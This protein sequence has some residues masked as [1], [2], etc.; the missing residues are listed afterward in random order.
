MRSM[1]QDSIEKGRNGSRASRRPSGFG[2]KILFQ[3]LEP[4]ILLC[5]DQTMRIS[6]RVCRLLVRDDDEYNANCI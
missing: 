2:G 3:F 4:T 1:R 6:S 5:S